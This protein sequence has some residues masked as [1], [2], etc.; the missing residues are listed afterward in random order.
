[1]KHF[2]INSSKR[3]SMPFWYFLLFVCISS[4]TLHAQTI[5]GTVKTKN[6]EVVPGA[7]VT[8][9]GTTKGTTTDSEGT[10][11]I[12]GTA[13][14][15]LV[16]SSIGYKSQ[17]VLI[18]NKT[19][20]DVTLEEDQSSLNEVVVVGYGTQK[21]VDLTGSV[22]RVNLEV[23][24]GAPNTNIAQFMQGAVPGLNVGVSSFSGGTPSIAIRGQTS[25]NGNRSVLIILDGVQ[26][27]GS[28]SSINPDDIASIDVLKDASSTAVYGAQAA[29]GV[30]LITSKKGGYNKKAKIS[31]TSAFTSQSPTVGNK[32]KPYNREQFLNALKEGFYD[33][34]YLAP[35]FTEPNPNFDIKTVV[36]A[37][38]ANPNKTELLPNDYNWFDEATNKGS[39]LENNLSISGGG[40][41]VSYLLS[42]G[43]V[44][45]KGF[46]IN[47]KF[48]RSTIRANLEINPT[49]WL[50]LGLVSSGSFVNQDGA[51]P[52]FG[53][54]N[55]TSPL[56]V[57]FDANGNVIPNPTNTVVPNPF[58]TY[59]VDDYDRNQYYFANIFADVNV[60][61]I[62]GLN[63]R[64]NFGNNARTS[65][66]YTSSQFEGNLT[67]RV[68]KNNQTYYDYTL[69]NI[70]TYTKGFG[71]HNLTTT[72][73]YGAIERKFNN[74]FV[75]GVGF[76]RLNLSFNELGNA[77]V[78]NAS[79]NSTR[80][81][82]AYQMARVNYKYA[83][84]Y[85]LTATVRRDGFSGFAKNNKSAIFP[86][87]AL[88]WIVSEESFM[89]KLPVVDFLKF[90]VGYGIA[91]NQTPAFSSL[92]L[93][94]VN[95]S[96][97]FGNGG[98]TA[99]GQQVNSLGNDNLRWER[100]AGLN[101]GLEFG[102]FKSRLSGTL[103]V[104][105]NKTTDLLFRVPLP[106]L[107]GF[108]DI[109]TNVGRLDNKGFESSLTYAVVQK[110]DFNWSATFN[111]WANT[112]KIVSLT[113]VD[114]NKDGVEDDIVATGTGG[115]Y[116]GRS[117][118]TIFDYQANGIY[119]LN[120]ER[121]PGFPVGSF[122]V[123]DQN[124]DRD[125]TAADRVFMGT[126]E[127][128]FRMSLQNTI[129]YKQFTLTVFL[130]SIQGGK[131]GYLGGNTRT[132]FRDDNAIRNNDLVGVDYWS[133]SNPN[134]KYARVISG[135]RAKV[136]PTI[137]ENRNFV[138]LQ[139][140]TLAYNFAPKML[141]K[142]KAQN[143][144]IY[145]SGKNL[146]TFTKWQ[147]WDPEAVIVNNGVQVFQG[148]TT[149]GRPIL[150]GYTAGL[151]LN[152]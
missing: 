6:S 124:G 23:Q 65:Q 16:I 125:I 110:K 94:G 63:Y 127:P 59:Y 128:K 15:T 21:K 73:L 35:N 134:G 151:M 11:T 89:S 40:D 102:L 39:I 58:N 88:G 95:Q 37:T 133:P 75:E 92:A 33:R 129:N 1:M 152:F 113:G 57:P 130:N 115:L 97:I 9:K 85:L 119:Q 64:L 105:H 93:V 36:D 5:K 135:T 99:F 38:M 144:S 103:E 77:D 147:G 66:R 112:N 32:L 71:K 100:T 14:Q 46:I 106:T 22:A 41:K 107:T 13:N 42:G 146:A 131:D 136:E 67:G 111:F 117:I 30:I 80:E 31:F 3:R 20:I 24:Q 150:R 126:L 140:V 98:T 34:A 52:S 141:E 143:I 142:I 53:V 49:D 118:N 51:E 61:F 56:L 74:T 121:L 45:Q 101:I 145:V 109:Q 132:Y 28:L 72:L 60:P 83:E 4:F 50:K 54:I 48:K 2:E 90:R 108:N 123:V 10:Y 27:N 116:I 79:S 86:T 139:D 69:D 25:L 78:R 18:G 148:M 87:F 96:Y 104:Y 138:R 84:K 12:S 8:I 81:A 19:I 62:K 120:E 17:E 114:N 70:L 29:N 137:Y 7:T 122:K 44:D 68:S 47:D 76:S 91:G 26:Y 82:L 43:F 149:D 55:I